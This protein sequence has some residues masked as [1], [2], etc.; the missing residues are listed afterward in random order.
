MTASSTLFDPG[1]A[2]GGLTDRQ[3]AVYDAARNTPGGITSEDAGRILHAIRGNHTATHTCTWC[4]SEGHGVLQ[5]LRRRGLLTRR[6]KTGLWQP[7]GTIQ[8]PIGGRPDPRTT[9]IPF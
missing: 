2:D 6:R 4:A 1:P 5:A 9:E 7:A 3:Q 8:A